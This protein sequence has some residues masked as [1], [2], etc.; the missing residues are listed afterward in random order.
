[1]RAHSPSTRPF[2]FSWELPLLQV[3]KGTRENPDKQMER[4]EKTHSAAIAANRR[5]EEK[6]NAERS[7]YTR[8]APMSRDFLEEGV[9]VDEDDDEEEYEMGAG[10]AYDDEEEEEEEEEEE[11]ARKE[12]S[13][14]CC[15]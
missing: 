9:G 8:A 11:D 4:L 14:V 7:R 1:M 13:K 6:Q 3:F 2:I 5:R 10:R 15:S 12:D